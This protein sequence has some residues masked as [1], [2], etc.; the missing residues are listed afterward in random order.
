MRSSRTASRGAR[1][2]PAEPVHC[3]WTFEQARQRWKPMT[4]A[5]QHVG[6]PGYQFQAGVMWDGGLVFG[7]VL[8]SGSRG[9]EVMRQELAPATAWC[10]R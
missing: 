7:P 10:S 4:R 3:E 6:M 2:R 9:M 8:S 1:S 5:V